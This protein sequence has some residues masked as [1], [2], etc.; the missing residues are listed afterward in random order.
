MAGAKAAASDKGAT[1]HI[2]RIA[3]AATLAFTIAELAN[4][5]F[6]FLAPMLAVQLLASAPS[7]PSLRQGL[8]MPL[9]IL[10]ATALAFGVSRLFSLSPLV[11]LALVGLVICWSFYGQR[12]GAPAAIMLLVQIAFCCIPVISTISFDLAWLFMIELLRGSIAAVVTVWIVHL[13]IPSPSAPEASATPAPSPAGHEPALAARIAISDT[14]ILYPVL[15]AFIARGDINNIVILMIALNLLRAVEPER[16]SRVAMA[17]IVGNL[18][19]GV[20][21]IFAYQFVV[22]SG[23]ILFFIL[24]VLAMGLWFGERMVRGGER[25]PVY[26]IAFTTFLLILGLGIAPLPGGS[27]ELLATRIIKILVA[28]AYTIGALSLF[29]WLRRQP[30][31]PASRAIG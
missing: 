19:G 2:L 22:L 3:I 11:L 23:S 26:A 14:L 18:L 28:S 20:V 27:E 6:S 15:I 9:V 25:A 13:L 16:S 29:G 10:I 21:A 8:A 12:R 24:I 5:D 31:S 7:A 30:K 1:R 17:I 4:W